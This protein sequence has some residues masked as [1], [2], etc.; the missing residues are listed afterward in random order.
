M[1]HEQKAKPTV[2]AR[3]FKLGDRVRT[4]NGGEGVV[5]GETVHGSIEVRFELA[6]MTFPWNP[7]D[8]T[9]IRPTPR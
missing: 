5:V 9:L 7:S 6:E 4:P 8:L 1:N 2:P 3:P